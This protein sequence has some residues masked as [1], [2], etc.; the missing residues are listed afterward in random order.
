MG[1]DGYRQ[2][3]DPSLVIY[4]EAVPQNSGARRTVER[5][6][7]TEFLHAGATGRVVGMDA[8]GKT[9]FQTPEQDDLA[10]H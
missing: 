3:F 10:G 4:R 9:K 2:N 5:G 8:A 1:T 6:Q 7:R